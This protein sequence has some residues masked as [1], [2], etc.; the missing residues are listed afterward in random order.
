LSVI[1]LLYQADPRNKGTVIGLRPETDEPLPC[2]LT[3]DHSPLEEAK[4]ELI[5]HGKGNYHQ[6]IAVSG[7]LCSEN[8]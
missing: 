4:Y 2:V 5:T 8:I 1:K 3:L 6:S 7:Q